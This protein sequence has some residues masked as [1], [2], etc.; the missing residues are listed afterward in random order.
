LGD[1]LTAEQMLILKEVLA[2][3]ISEA[4]L[5]LKLHQADSPPGVDIVDETTSYLELIA[6]Q[7]HRMQILE[8]LNMLL[9][10]G[11]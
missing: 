10:L 6:I 4:E 11:R 2:E 7:K 9:Q 3:S 8:Q 5:T 1:V